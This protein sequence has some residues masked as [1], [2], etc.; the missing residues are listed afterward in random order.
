MC[1]M[2]IPTSIFIY[3]TFIIAVLC[4]QASNAHQTSTAYLFGDLN[5]RGGINAELQVRLFD[6][7]RAVGLDN[8]NNGELTWGE[9]LSNVEAVEQY[10]VD[11]LKFT[12][13]QQQCATSFN[14]AWQLDTHFNEPYLLVP[15]SAQCGLQGEL[16]VN[17]SGFFS[18]DTEHKVLLSFSSAEQ[19]FSRVI[20]DGSRQL[21]LDT[22][23]GN[24]WATFNEFVKQGA[25]H[26]W[27]G[28]DHILFLISLLLATVFGL[29]K[30][31]NRLMKKPTSLRETG[32]KIFGV[33]TTFTIAHS[34]TLALTAINVIE[35]SSAWVEVGIAISVL[36]AALNN[37]YPLVRKLTLVTFAFGLLHGMG[38]AGV[39]GELGLPSD[40]KLLSI[41]AFN[42]GVEFGQLVI[43]LAALPLMFLIQKNN[44]K[45]R[46]CLVAGSSIIALI[47][48]L[49][50]IQR[51]PL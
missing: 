28:L 1:I 46:F 45:P 48:I 49:W 42:L 6:L 7:E 21:S 44:W 47:S 22:I 36:A 5:S 8:D 41:L 40:Q 11:A 10:L 19:N 30:P 18:I 3:C 38:F 2:K 33:A 35:L 16:Q 14:G 25:I 31:G 9:A 23:N 37:I 34:I 32:W 15:L 27:I 17:Y 26:I 51:V 20:S 50:I 12:R 4:S 43:I 24:A 13:N 39:L 29:E